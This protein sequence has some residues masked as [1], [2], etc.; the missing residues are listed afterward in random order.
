MWSMRGSKTVIWSWPKKGEYTPYT[1]NSY[2]WKAAGLRVS[3]MSE[4]Q[5]AEQYGGRR[6]GA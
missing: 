2:G 6:Y 5:V 4:E 3:N 1:N